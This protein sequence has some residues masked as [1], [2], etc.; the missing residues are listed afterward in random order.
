MNLNTF[1][2]LTFFNKIV[3]ENGHFIKIPNHSLIMDILQGCLCLI[4]LNILYYE[5]LDSAQYVNCLFK[6][7]IRMNDFVKNGKN[8]YCYGILHF[9]INNL[10]FDLKQ[11]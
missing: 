2:I 6:W 3:T 9:Q 7:C 11:S 10:S 8:L 1:S 5:F 4:G